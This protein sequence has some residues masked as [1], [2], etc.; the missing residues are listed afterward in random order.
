M[1]PLA[2]LAQGIGQGLFLAAEEAGE[3]VHPVM[4]GLTLAAA[5]RY[6]GRKHPRALKP[7]QGGDDKAIGRNRGVV[8]NHQ[9]ALGSAG[10]ARAGGKFARRGAEKM[11]DEQAPG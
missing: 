11:Q 10:L 2:G 3:A 5:D 7:A 4:R 6:R 8:W 9:N 1:E